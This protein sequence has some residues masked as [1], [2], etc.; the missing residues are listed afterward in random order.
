MFCDNLWKHKG[1]VFIM[2]DKHLEQFIEDIKRHEGNT[3]RVYMDTE[4]N[5]TCGWGHCLREGSYVPARAA[6]GFLE[7]DIALSLIHI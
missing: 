3:G 4:G 2:N 5:L 6:E 7:N 1:L